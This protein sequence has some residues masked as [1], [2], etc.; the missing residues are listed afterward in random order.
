LCY[1]AGQKSS[2]RG[3]FYASVKL[4]EFAIY[5]LGAELWRSDLYEASLVLHNAAAQ[6]YCHVVDHENMKKTLDAIFDHAISFQDKLPAYLILI[7]SSGS[8]HQLLETSRISTMVLQE[9]GAPVPE[10]PSTFTV[11]TYF[12]RV[13]LALRGKTD[14]FLINLPIADD[15]DFLVVE[16]LLSFTQF[17]GF[18]AYPTRTALI[19]YRTILSALKHGI[20]GPSALAFSGYAFF[21]C[22]TGNFKEGNRMGQVSLQLAERFGAWWPRLQLLVFGYVNHW[23]YPLRDSLEPLKRIQR[24]SLL[25]GDLEVYA[26]SSS[27]HLLATLNAGVSLDVLEPSSR[28]KCLDLAAIGQT[29]QLMMSIQLWSLVSDLRGGK[30]EK[31]G[32]NGSIYDATSS[33]NHCIKEGNKF[34][35]GNFYICRTI[36]Y[37]LVGDYERALHM[38]KKSFEQRQI[39]DIAQTFYQGLASLAAAWTSKSCLYNESLA[40]GKMSAKCVKHWADHC[41]ENF[42]NKQWLLEAEIAALNGKSGR[43]LAIFEQSINKARQEA[44]VHEE[45]IAYERLGCYQLRLGKTSDAKICFTNA[46]SAYEKWGASVLVDRMDDLLASTFRSR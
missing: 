3:N 22:A 6:A 24:G 41:P 39:C 18:M 16:Q 43:A 27:L 31:L 4:F 37:Y 1:E 21:L 28:T 40:L 10:N 26:V 32:V 15:A 23:T 7:Y 17:I 35:A 46:R 11:V 5:I 25:F 45:A 34:M 13:K 30:N 33:I 12:L 44:F 38:A 8:G 9:L 20:C 19:L 42:R 29:N 36:W 2:S 14:R